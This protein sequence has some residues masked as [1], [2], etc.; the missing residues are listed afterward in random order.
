MLD[1]ERVD[2]TLPNGLSLSLHSHKLSKNSVIP[3]YV[4]R[5]SS[6]PLLLILPRQL[7]EVLERRTLRKRMMMMI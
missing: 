2:L 6:Q 3:N 5:H 4:P 7:Q 1:S